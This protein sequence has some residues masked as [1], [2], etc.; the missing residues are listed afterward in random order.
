MTDHSLCVACTDGQLR[1]M[2]GTQFVEGQREG[3][4]EVCYN[5]TYGTVC[6]DRWDIID[7]GVVCRQLQRSFE[8]SNCV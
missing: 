5:D 6:D 4:V 8:G 3:R 7:A 1:L 2:N